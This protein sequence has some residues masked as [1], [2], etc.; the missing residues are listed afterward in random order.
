MSAS[1]FTFVA[2]AA[3]TSLLTGCASPK[4]NYAPASA[5]ISE[6]PLNSV[7]VSQ[8]GDVMLRQGTYREHDS[9]YLENVVKP[10]WS[11][12]LHPG[13]Y[14]KQ[15]EDEKAEYFIPSNGPDGGRVDKSALADPWQSL[16]VRKNKPGVCVITVFNL[17]TC[18]D[19]IQVVRRKKAIATEDTFQQTLIYNGKVGNKVNIAYREFSGSLARPAFNNSVEYDLSESGVVGYKGAQLEILEATNQHIKYRVLRNFNAAAL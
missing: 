2:A 16:M 1:K 6:P 7:I 18:G 13:Y 11:Y 5:A 10:H 12:T 4:F 3:V 8:I 15:G 14:L 9:F 17:V 19:E